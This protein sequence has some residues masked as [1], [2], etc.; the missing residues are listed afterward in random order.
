M[1]YTKKIM[2]QSNSWYN[3]GLRK[4]QVR[5]MSGAIVSLQQSLQYNRENI[6]ARNLLGL[7][8]Y[9]IGEVSE[10]LVEWIISK[11]L[12]PKDNLADR[13]IDE[14][15]KSAKKLEQINQA[16]KKYNQCLTYCQQDGEDLAVI[17]LK[18]VVASHPTFLKAYQLLAL[19]YLK[20]EQYAKARQV[21][22]RAHKLDATNEIT[23]RYMHELTKL[24][25]KKT[26]KEK[27]EKDQT[28]KNAATEKLLCYDPIGK[29]YFHA[30]EAELLTAFYEANRDFNANGYI[31][32]NDVYGYLNLDFIPELHGRGWSIDYMSEMWDNCWIDFSYA[33]QQT[34]DGLEVY[35]VTAFKEPIEDYLNFDPYE[36]LV[37]SVTKSTIEKLKNDLPF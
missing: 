21:L 1:D 4:A 33:K 8:Y 35:Y 26:A 31:A 19:L 23:I 9:G 16:V 14:V 25:N 20:T 37:D 12:K 3:D 5:D 6:A 10:A 18:K 13:F 22:R 17:Q 27:E 2:Y 7:V 36:G 32:L 29:R 24:H 11:N 28:V 15:Q 34:D 30:T